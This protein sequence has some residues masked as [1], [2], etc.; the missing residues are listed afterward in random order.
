MKESTMHRQRLL[1]AAL[2]ASLIAIANLA[3]AQTWPST[4]AAARPTRGSHS[5]APAGEGPG[6]QG[7]QG[8]VMEGDRAGLLHPNAPGLIVVMPPSQPSTTV[9]VPAPADSTIQ[10]PSSPDDGRSTQ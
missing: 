3:S 7:S 5:G 9:I 6:T 2:G 10:S 1:G 8:Q 4:D